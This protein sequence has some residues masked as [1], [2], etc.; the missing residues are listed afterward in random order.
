M[1]GRFY[2]VFR[3]SEYDALEKEL[4]DFENQSEFVRDCF[5][6]GWIDKREKYVKQFALPRQAYDSM[7]EVLTEAMMDV[8][9]FHLRKQVWTSRLF[10]FFMILG[11]AGLLYLISGSR[12]SALLM[13]VS[14]L[15]S[16]IAAAVNVVSIFGLWLNRGFVKS[17]IVE[18]NYI[19]QREGV[20]SVQ[21]R[22]WIGAALSYLTAFDFFPPEQLKYKQRLYEH[23]S[24]VTIGCA[25]VG[26][27]DDDNDDDF[28]LGNL[29]AP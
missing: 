2:Y 17:M 12:L 10:L 15:L 5:K 8:M 22:N 28:D 9:K 11:V 24:D 1:K 27:Y 29:R 14:L 6:H 3:V 16:V 13:V 19:G 20:W 23:C 4:S 7:V 26:D 18:L 21:G 25:K